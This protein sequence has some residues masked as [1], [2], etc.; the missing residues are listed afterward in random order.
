MRCARGAAP[1]AFIRAVAVPSSAHHLH[2]PAQPL[3][4]SVSPQISCFETYRCFCEQ[5]VQNICSCRLSF[6]RPPEKCAQR[7]SR[8]FRLWSGRPASGA[9]SPPFSTIFPQI[10]PLH[11]AAQVASTQAPPLTSHE[12]RKLNGLPLN[13]RPSHSL[14]LLCG[15]RLNVCELLVIAWL[16]LSW[17]AVLQP[18]F[19]FASIFG[20]LLSFGTFFRAGHGARAIK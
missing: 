2:S 8:R 16:A 18:H 19:R 12:P 15:M 10:A 1:D 6:W 4:L 14:S 17:C 3:V 20:K 5:I 7:C 9:Q 13:R 11:L